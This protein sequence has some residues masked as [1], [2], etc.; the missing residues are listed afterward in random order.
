MPASARAS[1]GG[2]GLVRHPAPVVD[3]GECRMRPHPPLE[4]L[5]A[6]LAED[7][8]PRAAAIGNPGERVQHLH[9]AAA[10]RQAAGVRHQELTVPAVHPGH[11]GERRPAGI[12][13]D[14]QRP[15]MTGEALHDVVARQHD[16]I[17]GAAGSLLDQAA[18]RGKRPYRR[19]SEIG[20]PQD[21]LGHV[22]VDVVDH[23][24]AQRLERETHGNQLRVVEV[25]HIRPQ[26]QRLAKD[27]WRRGDHPPEPA[28]RRRQRADLDPVDRL[29]A[30]VGNHQGHVVPAGREGTGLLLEDPGVERRVDGGE[31]RH[32]RRPSGHRRASRGRA[33]ATRKKPSISRISSIRARI[34]K[35]PPERSDWVIDSMLSF[36]P[37][38]RR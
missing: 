30:S 27:P 8:Q 38:Q 29:V 7:H 1:C 28:P 31:D 20:L 13:P 3:P 18:R 32:P 35:I 12:I 5:G 4:L 22:L 37:H 24:L 16:Q 34:M 25:V 9:R 23:P 15:G 6:E 14:Q 21:A 26:L 10:K 19:G 17:E 2:R 33:V 36:Q 11:I